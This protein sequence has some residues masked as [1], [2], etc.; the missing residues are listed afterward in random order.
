MLKKSI[1]WIQL[2]SFLWLILANPTSLFSQV[3][4]KSTIAVLPFDS[5]GGISKNEALTLADRLRSELVNLQTFSV[6]ERGQMQSILEEQ[7]LNL[8]G[9]VSSECAIEAGR[10]LGVKYMVTGDVGKVGNILTIDTRMFDVATGKIVQAVQKDYKGDVSG[11][12]GLMKSIAYDLAGLKY[13]KKGGLSWKWLA[14]GGIALVGG[15]ILLMASSGD[16][17]AEEKEGAN[18]PDP[19]WPPDK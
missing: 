14:A 18:L 4:E 6:I 16:G 7:G 10:L 2:V 12:L 1:I 8:S 11:L 3:Q 19:I 17:G 5:K 9:C 13:E 15:V